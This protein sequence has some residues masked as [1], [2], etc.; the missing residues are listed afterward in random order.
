MTAIPEESRDL[1]D[2]V[3]QV[4]ELRPGFFEASFRPI[5]PETHLARQGFSITTTQGLRGKNLTE[6][7]DFAEAHW[8]QNY[9]SD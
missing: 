7:L 4:R 1:G 9:P 8:R 3:I 6:V 5:S 2:V